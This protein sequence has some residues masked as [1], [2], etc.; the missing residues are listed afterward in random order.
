MNTQVALTAPRDG[1]VH[2]LSF[3]NLA[4]ARAQRRGA[5]QHCCR[6]LRLGV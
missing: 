2:N 5:K 4:H 3:M 1:V 6:A